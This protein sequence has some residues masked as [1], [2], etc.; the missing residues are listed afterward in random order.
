VS[1]PVLSGA[2]ERPLDDYEFTFESY[3][4]DAMRI[5]PDVRYDTERSCVRHV[6]WSVANTRASQMFMMSST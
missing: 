6:D 2:A 3:L 5:E 4:D 1:M